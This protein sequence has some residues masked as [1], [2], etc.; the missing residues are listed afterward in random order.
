MREPGLAGFRSTVGGRLGWFYGRF[1]RTL[2]HL[3]ILSGLG[4]NKFD[5]VSLI[6][7]NQRNHFEDKTYVSLD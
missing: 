5:R 2:Q 3:Q 7:L 1:A 4:G 6:E